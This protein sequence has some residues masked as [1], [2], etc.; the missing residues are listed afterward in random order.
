MFKYQHYAS[1]YSSVWL[2]LKAAFP[3]E[4]LSIT[5]RLVQLGIEEVSQG[6]G[7]F[8]FKERNIH[9]YYC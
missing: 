7:G 4:A 6:Q 2:N 3:P 1:Y 9:D 5:L 8:F